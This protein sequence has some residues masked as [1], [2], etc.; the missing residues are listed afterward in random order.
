[1]KAYTG[2]QGAFQ[3][4]GQGIGNLVGL[5]IQNKKVDSEVEKNEAQRNLIASQ[6]ARNLQETA[7]S[8]FDLKLANDMYDTTL[9]IQQ[10]H[11][12]EVRIKNA[13]NLDK[14]VLY[15]QQFEIN[16]AQLR[17][18]ESSIAYTTAKTE[19]E[20]QNCALT[21]A[22]ILQTYNEMALND[23]RRHY[24][25]AQTD[26]ENTTRYWKKENLKFQSFNTEQEYFYGA[27]LLEEKIRQARSVSE[28]NEIESDW[29]GAKNFS[30][31]LKNLGAA[32]VSFG[33]GMLYF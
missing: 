16:N 1:M 27:R 32:T 13:L 6:T 9:A 26:T 31:V 30:D 28:L 14:H 7:K 8:E 3:A 19:T 25:D 22:R 21:A 20:K 18:I 11:L 24:L 17:S 15:G 29:R 4:V 33:K 5:S 10:E 23:A 12:N 2:N